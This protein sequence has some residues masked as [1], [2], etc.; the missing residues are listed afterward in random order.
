MRVRY[1]TEECQTAL[2]AHVELIVLTAQRR[3]VKRVA[4]Q[5]AISL[6]LVMEPGGFIGPVWHDCRVVAVGDTNMTSQ[7]GNRIDLGIWQILV[8][9]ALLD[10]TQEINH[11]HATLGIRVSHADTLAR[12]RRDDL[13]GEVRLGAD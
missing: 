10:M 1:C 9:A 6:E 13:V 2:L 3:N 11:C 8:D 12:A 7:S 5:L 4:N